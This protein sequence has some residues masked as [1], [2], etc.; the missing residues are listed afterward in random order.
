VDGRQ[1]HHPRRPADGHF[2][3]WF[4]LYNPGTNWVDLGGYYLSDTPTNM[5]QWAI[6]QGTTILPRLF[7][8]LG[9]WHAK[10]E[11]SQPTGSP[12]ELFPRQGGEAIALFAPDGTLIDAVTFDCNPRM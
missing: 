9:R 7:A 11:Q 12:R 1:R 3:D 2:E 4:E 8:G 10:P 6:P 5:T